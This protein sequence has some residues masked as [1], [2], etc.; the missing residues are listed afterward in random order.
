MPTNAG[1]PRKN[2]GGAASAPTV[3]NYRERRRFLNTSTS[4]TRS[5]W[6]STPSR[7]PAITLAGERYVERLAASKLAAIGRRE[8]IANSVE[9]YVALAVTVAHDT[10]LHNEER[11]TQRAR[12]AAS[13][14][15]DA[16]DLANALEN[17]YRAMWRRYLNLG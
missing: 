14:L 9:E 12:M 4:T 16:D 8:W 2:S 10:S 7:A 6:L 13:Q 11:Q 5:T 15:C 3:C 1:W 17:A